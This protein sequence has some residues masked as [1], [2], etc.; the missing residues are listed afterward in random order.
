MNK[1]VKMKFKRRQ[2]KCS[3]D[4]RKLNAWRWSATTD[5]WK[6][7]QTNSCKCKKTK[8]TMPNAIIV[9]KKAIVIRKVA[10]DIARNKTRK[11]SSKTVTKHKKNKGAYAPVFFWLV[12]RIRPSSATQS[13]AELGSH[14]SR[15]P[16]CVILS[17]RNESN[18][19]VRDPKRHLVPF[20][21]RLART[22]TALRMTRTKKRKRSVAESTKRL[23]E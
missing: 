8:S 3:V 1:F 17:E 21:P 6:L 15:K 18:F 4:R 2:Q 13:V 12:A 20:D 9:Q 16:F 19:F 22:S 10:Q 14:S 5:K 11:M 7:R 23:G